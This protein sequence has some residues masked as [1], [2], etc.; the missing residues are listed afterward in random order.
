MRL[1]WTD[2]SVQDNVVQLT[3]L[4][5]MFKAEP[6]YATNAQDAAGLREHRPRLPDHPPL[7]YGRFAMPLL[8]HHCSTIEADVLVPGRHNTEGP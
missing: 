2:G 6:G 3:H 8:D 1:H 4:L 5:K 7:C